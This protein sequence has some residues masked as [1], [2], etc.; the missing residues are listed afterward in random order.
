[1][2]NERQLA[3]AV[4]LYLIDENIFFPYVYDSPCG[5]NGYR[6][7][8]YWPVTLGPYYGATVK[9]QGGRIYV[10]SSLVEDNELNR[11]MLSRRLTRRGFQVVMAQ[12][13]EKGVDMAGPSC[14]T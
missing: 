1:M 9:R 10:H 4:H 3:A 8:S 13:G 7:G 5:Q 14:L 12:D 11:Y 2:S 6:E